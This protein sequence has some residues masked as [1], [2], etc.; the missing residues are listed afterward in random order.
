MDQDAQALRRAVIS[1]VRRF[2]LLDQAQ[3][4]C[5]MPLS[6]SHAHALMEILHAPGLK[7]NELAERL[8]LSKSN[9]S[10][11]V[12]KLVHGKRVRRSKDDADGRAYQ[13][14]LTESG[15]Q[16]AEAL[17]ARS[18]A[19]FRTL[20]ASLPAGQRESVTR[21]LAL[22]AEAA[23]LEPAKAGAAGERHPQT[24]WSSDAPLAS[25]PRRRRARP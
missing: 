1:F 9:V 21:A 23:R 16:L 19:R 14:S 24:G 18:L 4:P 11:L 5:G 8:G 20:L 13:L 17:D 12:G 22:L 10:R 15:Q 6:L 25:N 3:T 7:Q 2:G